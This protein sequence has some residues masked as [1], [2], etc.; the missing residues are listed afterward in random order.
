MDD[1]QVQVNPTYGPYEG[2]TTFTVTDDIPYAVG[3]VDANPHLGQG[4]ATQGVIDINRFGDC[5]T[6]V[7]YTEFPKGSGVE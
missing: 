7:C 2:Y 4:G 6:P 1:M 3:T 5:L